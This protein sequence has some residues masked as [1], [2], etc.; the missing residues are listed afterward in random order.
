MGPFCVIYTI[1]LVNIFIGWEKGKGGGLVTLFGRILTIP[2]K[3]ASPL[4]AI[5]VA[6]YN[7]S[8]DGLSKFI[9]QQIYYHS[10]AAA[11]ARL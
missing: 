1:L 10:A 6:H 3:K 7:I 9:P 8:L 4:S 2:R 11:A 5:S